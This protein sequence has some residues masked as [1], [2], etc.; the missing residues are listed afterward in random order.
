MFMLSKVFVGSNSADPEALF[1]SYVNEID[2]LN[3]LKGSPF[4]IQL[5]DSEVDKDNLSVSMIMEA[6][7]I[8]LSKV[9]RKPSQRHQP[10]LHTHDPGRRCWRA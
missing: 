10:L 2:L 3:S 5:M 1:E 6:G 8:D 9:L 7:E 4:I